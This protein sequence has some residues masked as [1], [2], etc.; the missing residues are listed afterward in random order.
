MGSKERKSL[1]CCRFL[2]DQTA[3]HPRRL[4]FQPSIQP[5]QAPLADTGHG[6]DNLNDRTKLLRGGAAHYYGLARHRGQLRKT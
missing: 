2:L 4:V 6:L 1:L 3:R 5:R